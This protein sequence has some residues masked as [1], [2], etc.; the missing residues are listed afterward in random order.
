MKSYTVMVTGYGF[1]NIEAN[2]EEEALTAVNSMSKKDFDWDY[3]FSADDA[4]VVSEREIEKNKGKTYY[5]TVERKKLEYMTTEA[6]NVDEA[7]DKI[8]ELL[9][10]EDSDYSYDFAIC[11]EDGETLVDWIN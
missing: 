5:V 2:S 9:K 4:S 7:I 8:N 1:A 10:S 11:D 6:A 3:D